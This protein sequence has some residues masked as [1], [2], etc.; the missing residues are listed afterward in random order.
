M[1]CKHCNTPNPEG[2][3]YCQGCGSPLAE[4]DYSQQYDNVPPQQIQQPYR[5]NPMY[6]ENLNKSSN[7]E[8][9]SVL[10]WIGVF[11]LTSIPIVYF[12]MLFIWGF[13]NTQDKTF[14][15][16]AK[17]QLIMGVITIV[18]TIVLIIIF[19]ASMA[20]SSSSS[21]YY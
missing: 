20:M 13:G 7:A 10:K 2:C 3:S 15:N 16:Y 14:K 9:I 12:I 8:P 18:L 11:F 1:I 6:S 19:A 21:T 5:P 4:S 17:A